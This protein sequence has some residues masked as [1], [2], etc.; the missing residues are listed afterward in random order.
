MNKKQIKVL[1]VGVI[2]ITLMAV[3]P[4]WIGNKTDESSAPIDLVTNRSEKFIGFHFIFSQP[5]YRQYHPVSYSSKNGQL[6]S[7]NP[8]S[9]Y[10]RHEYQNSRIGLGR[11]VVQIIPVLLIC[12]GFICTYRDKKNKSGTNIIANGRDDIES[13]N[14]T[15]NSDDRGKQKIRE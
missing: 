1:W 12:G 5:K 13:E 14:H 7:S 15:K 3:F 2:L 4:P 10:S 9:Y 8:K 6:I 11:F